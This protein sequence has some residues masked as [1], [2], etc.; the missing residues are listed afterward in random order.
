M[1]TALAS[2]PRHVRSVPI[3]F[4]SQPL[5]SVMKAAGYNPERRTLFIWEGVTNYLTEDAVD[6]TLR[7]CASAAVGSKVLFTYVHRQVLDVPHAFEGTERLFATLGAAGERWTFGL[8]PTCLRS[9]LAQRGL[10]LDEDV[11]ASEY[12]ARCFGS[13]ATRMRGYE[14]Y[15]VAVARVSEASENA[16]A[17]QQPAAAA[18]A[19]RRR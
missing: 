10:I 19:A 18:G 6:G 7:W 4:N 5:P 9:F 12:R 8:D 13:A 16:D 3:D 1:E 15:R 14:F 11:G 2:A 17:A